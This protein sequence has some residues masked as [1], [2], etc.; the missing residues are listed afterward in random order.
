MS[1]QIKRCH[2][3][4]QYVFSL[5]VTFC[6]LITL[7]GCYLPSKTNLQPSNSSG[8]SGSGQPVP[9]EI[10]FILQ[11]TESIPEEAKIGIEILDEVTGLPYNKEVFDLIKRDDLTYSTK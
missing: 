5:L 4:S 8:I 3:N 9:I 2:N 1:F 11:L 6:L 7:T 10:T